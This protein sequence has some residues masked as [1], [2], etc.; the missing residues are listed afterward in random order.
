LWGLASFL[1][2]SGLM[3]PQRLR[4]SRSRLIRDNQPVCIS[5]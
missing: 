1:S 3:K 4:I 5:G 2:P